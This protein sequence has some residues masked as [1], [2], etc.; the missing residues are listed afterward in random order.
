MNNRGCCGREA[1]CASVCAGWGGSFGE[2]DET[3]H[4]VARS[5]IRLVGNIDAGHARPRS[6][7]LGRI[8]ELVPSWTKML[9]AQKLSDGG[10]GVAKPRRE[11]VRIAEIVRPASRRWTICTSASARRRSHRASSMKIVLQLPAAVASARA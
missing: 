3:A 8:E 6:P 9:R 10:A 2:F 11:R 5:R 7:G 4:L 1:N